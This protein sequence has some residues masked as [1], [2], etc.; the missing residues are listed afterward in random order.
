[1][2]SFTLCGSIV[3]NPI[4]YRLVLSPPTYEIRQYLLLNLLKPGSHL[5]DKHNTSEPFF[6]LWVLLL[7]FPRVG[8]LRCEHALNEYAYLPPHGLRPVENASLNGYKHFQAKRT[9]HLGSKVTLLSSFGYLYTFQISSQSILDVGELTYKR[10]R[11]DIRRWRN[12]FIRWRTGRWRTDTLA[13]R[14]VTSGIGNSWFCYLLST[15]CSS[16]LR[17]HCTHLPVCYTF[18]TIDKQEPFTRSM[19]LPY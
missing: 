16:S 12:N 11:T 19:Q 3:A 18:A 9:I 7:Q 17:V 14:P 2:C 4:I 1:M 13:K 15:L 5:C 6:C 10:W 8:P